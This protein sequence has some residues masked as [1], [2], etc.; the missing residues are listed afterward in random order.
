MLKIQIYHDYEIMMG[1]S[2]NTQLIHRSSILRNFALNSE[3]LLAI[4]YIP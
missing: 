1:T 3:L 4:E 2:R